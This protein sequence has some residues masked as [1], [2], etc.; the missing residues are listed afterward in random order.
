[1]IEGSNNNTKWIVLDT[2]QDE[3]SLSGANAS[4][5]FDIEYQNGNFRYLRIRQTG[6]NSSGC[7][8]LTF[9]ALEFIGTLSDDKQ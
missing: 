7:D 1:M 3:T 9:S 6:H 5:T 4:R 2:R 8:F